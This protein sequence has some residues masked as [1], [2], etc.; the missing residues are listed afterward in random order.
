MDIQTPTTLTIHSLQTIQTIQITPIIPAIQTTIHK[1]APIGL[2]STR[3][4]VIDTQGI[5]QVPLEAEATIQTPLVD[6]TP[7]VV[8]IQREMEA[9]EVTR[10]MEVFWVT[11]D[12][13]DIMQMEIVLEM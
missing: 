9:M 3:V 10:E 8:D 12:M 4:V 6:I 13:M 11:T 5:I 2:D 1:T 7:P